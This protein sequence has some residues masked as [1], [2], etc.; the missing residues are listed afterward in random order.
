[1]SGAAKAKNKK[2]WDADVITVQSDPD[3]AS[4]LSG[5]KLQEYFAKLT[6]KEAMPWTSQQVVEKILVPLRLE[7]YSTQFITH[8]IEGVVLINLDE[9]DFRELQIDSLGDRRMLLGALNG[10]IS[11]QH[12]EKDKVIWSG[13]YPPTDAGFFDVQYYA[14]LTEFCLYKFC[15]C[16]MPTEFYSINRHKID[17]N[18]SPP[19][20]KQ[21][22]ADADSEEFAFRDVKDMNNSMQP[23]V[24]CFCYKMEVEFRF[25]K[26]INQKEGKKP[27]I[28][29]HPG[30]DTKK[31]N[32]IRTCWGKERLISTRGGVS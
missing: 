2:D 19:C 14:S 15:C 16:L 26:Y 7:K 25:G 24:C 21:C 30:L 5:D 17:R 9:N 29:R 1:M 23:T 11:T 12:I 31:Q 18:R 10:I 13:N 4:K 28:I 8:K 20:I 3:D 32:I 27:L 22:C 6:Y